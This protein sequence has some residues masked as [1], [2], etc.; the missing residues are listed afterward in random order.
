MDKVLTY[1]YINKQEL[2]ASAGNLEKIKT[3]INFG[4][5]T[6]ALEKIN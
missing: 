4:A 3:S 5:D 1:W 2:L 6:F